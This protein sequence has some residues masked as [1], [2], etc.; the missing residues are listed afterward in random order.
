LLLDA[1]VARFDTDE[2][3]SGIEAFLTS[4]KTRWP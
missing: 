3:G 1:A 4:G 2:A